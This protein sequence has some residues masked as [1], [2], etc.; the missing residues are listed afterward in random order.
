MAL[1]CVYGCC[2]DDRGVLPADV[3]TS[4][5]EMSG[6]TRVHSGGNPVLSRP[7]SAHMDRQTGRVNLLQRETIHPSRYDLKARCSARIVTAPCGDAQEGGS[8]PGQRDRP[9]SDYGDALCVKRVRADDECCFL[10]A[11]CRCAGCSTAS[12]TKRRKV[13]DELCMK[14]PQETEWGCG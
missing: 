9:T 8:I 10:D 1:K 6:T 3:P 2:G 13:T 11:V 14:Q 12:A 4:R 5:G 7:P